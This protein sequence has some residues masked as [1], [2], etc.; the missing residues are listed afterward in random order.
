MSKQERLVKTLA[1]NFKDKKMT[2]KVD[3]YEYETLEF[4]IQTDQVPAPEIAE[5]FTDKAFYN[6]YAERNFKDK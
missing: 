5:F 3:N 4:L 1:E 2:R 6:W